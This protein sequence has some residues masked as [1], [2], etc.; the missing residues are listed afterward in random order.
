MKR[1][2]ASTWNKD[3]LLRNVAGSSLLT[4]EG[5]IT[6]YD[7]YIPAVYGVLHNLDFPV[8]CISKK[9]PL[10]FIADFQHSILLDFSKMEHRFYI[11]HFPERILC[12]KEDGPDQ[13][14]HIGRSERARTG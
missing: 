6:A 9:I 12:G 10:D 3:K 7:N 1:L 11:D 8:C 14:A 2:R 13:S 4:L 5:S